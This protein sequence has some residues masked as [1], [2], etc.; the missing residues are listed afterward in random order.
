MSQPNTSSLE[1]PTAR[2]GPRSL[3]D[4]L[5]FVDAAQQRS[6]I[7][8]GPNATGTGGS[9]QGS[10][11]AVDLMALLARC[12]GN[13]DLI[14]RVLTR[15]KNTGADD[16]Q[17]LDG[18]IEHADLDAVVEISHRLKG[19]ASNVSAPGLQRIASEMEHLGHSG[20]RADLPAALASLRREWSEFERYAEAFAPAIATPSPCPV[21]PAH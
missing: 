18:A 20:N 5:A 21:G 12:L 19:A 9:G 11:P 13:I 1:R 10:A 15:F 16:I 2:P 3:A 14:V 6:A 4:L 17:H 7:A 8:G